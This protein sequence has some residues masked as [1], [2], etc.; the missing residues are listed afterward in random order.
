[1]MDPVLQTL[2]TQPNRKMKCTS[3]CRGHFKVTDTLDTPLLVK[4]QFFFSLFECHDGVSQIQALG[5][6]LFST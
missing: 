6:Y 4:C 2:T 1:M 3:V 5:R